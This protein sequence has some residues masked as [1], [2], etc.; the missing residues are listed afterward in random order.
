GREKVTN[1][2]QSVIPGVARGLI[3]ELNAQADVM[4]GMVNA[5]ATELQD[6]PPRAISEAGYRRAV[7]SAEAIYNELRQRFE[8]ARLA[9][10]TTQPDVSIMTAASVPQ[11][12]NGDMRMQL[13]LLGVAV[14]MGFGVGLAIML[15]LMDR[16]VR[17]AEQVSDGMHLTILGA[18]PDLSARRKL[19]TTA[20]AREELIEALRGIRLN[21]THAYGSAGPLMV[22]VTSPGPGDGKTFLTTNLGTTFAELGMRTLLID[23]D[24]R[25]GTMHHVMKLNRKPGLTDYLARKVELS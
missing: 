24:T 16:R 5:A 7:A 18:I 11:Q 15:E 19:F 13:L 22:T 12:P 8:N 20:P 23:A 17:Y 25:R 2:E 3:Q 6:I 10:E 14:G 4:G 9:A 21:M 1:L